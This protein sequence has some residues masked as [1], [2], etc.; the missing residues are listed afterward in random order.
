MAI[1][2]TQRRKDD[3][4]MCCSVTIRRREEALQIVEHTYEIH[5]E[6]VSFAR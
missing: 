1:L 3:R 4:K 6:T 2:K 5:S